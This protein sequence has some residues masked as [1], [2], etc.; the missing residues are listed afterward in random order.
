MPIQH[1][2]DIY[3]P[4]LLP[5]GHG[6]PLWLPQ[7]LSNLPPDCV[8]HGTQIGDLG[9][10]ANDGGFV[11]LFNVCKDATDPVNLDRV[12]PG[13][14]PLTSIPGV[15][16]D[17]E[18]HKRNSVI[19]SP[20]MEQ[21]RVASGFE[22]TS[23]RVRAAVLVL[24]DGAERYDS[25]QPSLFE[26][27][28]IANAHSW[29]KYYNGL[30]QGWNLA[31][32]SLYLVT[33]CDKCHCWGNACYS[34]RTESRSGS[35]RFSATRDSGRNGTSHCGWEGQT[36]GSIRHQSHQRDASP[37]ATANQTVF[38][39]GYSISVRTQPM[40][41]ALGIK[42]VAVYKSDSKLPRT[43]RT[44]GARAP[45]APRSQLGLMPAVIRALGFSGTTRGAGRRDTRSLREQKLLEDEVETSAFEKIDIPYH[46]TNGL[47]VQKFL[48]SSLKVFNPSGL[49]NDYI[50]D[51]Y[52]D[53]TVALTHDDH[54]WTGITDKI[55]NPLDAAE[56]ARYAIDNKL[57]VI[58]KGSR[59]HNAWIARRRGHN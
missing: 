13:F 14:A 9:H 58:N 56:L 31:N 42:K 53:A 27:Y 45:Y 51:S 49:I 55:H 43:F 47:A 5:K 17:L 8:R 22:F 52:P 23:P 6:Y 16:E 30:E 24:P 3:V 11:Y 39:R 25:E 35:L 4:L 19:C 21:R 40:S 10:F 12:P 46:T 1:A 37:G 41:R 7:P 34:R 20:A 26:E 15:R 54:L 33:G 50:L 32:G 44:S 2:Q 28:A 36:D 57:V 38:M 59:P 29:Y 18:A 48:G